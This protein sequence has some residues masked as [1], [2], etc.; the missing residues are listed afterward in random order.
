MPA[1]IKGEIFLMKNTWSTFELYRVLLPVV[2]STLLCRLCV[3]KSPYPPKGKLP[4]HIDT[5]VSV[6]SMVKYISLTMGL[7][8]W[9]S[10]L[11]QELLKS[12]CFLVKE[13][14]NVCPIALLVPSVTDPIHLWAISASS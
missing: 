1:L 7:G 14:H 3:L 13:L 10:C 5:F 2:V 6:S 12:R 4:W 8:N 9:I 11:R